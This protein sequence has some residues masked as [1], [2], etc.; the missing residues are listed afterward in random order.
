MGDVVD[1]ARSGAGSLGA[2]HRT[3]D[4]ATVVGL[5]GGFALVVAV[6]AFVVSS[7]WST[8]LSIDQ[9]IRGL[10]SIGRIVG[11]MV[12]GQRQRCAA[13]RGK[14]AGFKLQS[15]RSVEKRGLGSGG[16]RNQAKG[17]GNEAHGVHQIATAAR[18]L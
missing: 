16:C 8:G 15:G 13:E 5:A 9:L 3:L 12:Q 11:Q 6:L 2:P 4:L 7:F 14:L 10:P 17:E 1:Q 18:R